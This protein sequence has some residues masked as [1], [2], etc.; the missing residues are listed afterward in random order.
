MNENTKKGLLIG[1][2]VLALI[3]VGFAYSQFAGADTP[4]VVKTIG[5]PT[6]S[7]K[8]NALKAQAAG[9]QSGGAADDASGAV[10]P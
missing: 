2:I 6:V 9:T 7:E 10:T 5:G 4:Q 3:G 8:D 1:V